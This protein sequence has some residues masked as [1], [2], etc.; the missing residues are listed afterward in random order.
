MKSAPL[1]SILSHW[2]KLF[3]DFST[4]SYDFYDAVEEGLARRKLPEARTSMVRWTEGGVLSPDREY[5]RIEGS[6]F[7][8]DLCAA[9]FGTGYFFSWW[10]TPKPPQW[11]LFYLLLFMLGCWAESRLIAS[12][13]WSAFQNVASLDVG[14]LALRFLL[15]NPFTIATLSILGTLL[16]VGVLA[17][18]GFREPE[19]AILTVPILGWVYERLFAPVTFYRLDTASMFRT[20][21]QQAVL[22]A[23]D[24]L[25]TQKGLKALAPEERKPTLDRLG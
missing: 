13:I 17:R 12:W 19:E 1:D 22:E 11:V 4:S 18:G 20:T 10:L 14:V 25:T 2:S 3:E 7:R 16:V 24:A 5:L 15:Q 21:V 8:F 23:L 9:P 6:G